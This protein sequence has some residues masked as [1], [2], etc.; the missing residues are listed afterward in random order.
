MQFIKLAG[1][2]LVVGTQEKEMTGGEKALHPDT[3][4]AYP[5]GRIRKFR[6]PLVKPKLPAEA[7]FS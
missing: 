1:F 5:S 4:L 2:T 3:W 6:T 7:G